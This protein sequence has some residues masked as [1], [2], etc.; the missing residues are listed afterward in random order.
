MAVSIPKSAFPVSDPGLPKAG[1]AS[2]RLEPAA[3]FQEALAAAARRRA[4]ASEEH[5][6]PARE[7][8]VH[9]GDT[10][11]EIVAAQLDQLGTG[12]SR[13]DLYETVKR[14]AAANGLDDPDRIF[15]G[16]KIDLT[17]VSGLAAN[18]VPE[19]PLQADRPETAQDSRQAF[20]PPAKGMITSPFGMRLHPLLKV[21]R[22]HDGIDIGLPTGTPV[23]PIA[24]GV[25]TFAGPNGGY[26]QMV[27][28]DH[29]NGL[30]SRYG[31]LSKLLVKEGDEI[32]ADQ[33]LGHSGDTGLSTGPHLHLE[34]RR[35]G[36]PID[37]LTLLSRQ[38]IEAGSILAQ[39]RP[40]DKG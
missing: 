12:Y 28:I 24:P 40:Q 20:Q 38:E 16:R 30:T 23:R 39:A 4:E 22:Q 33:I 17:V 9:P 19:T 27:E 2:S 3:A 25:V 5:A 29:G 13:R 8:T 21:E 34:I 18:P 11:S 31:H 1:S 35:Q 36:Q 32:G 6:A 10:L 7:H 14:V 37:P 15:P 26:G